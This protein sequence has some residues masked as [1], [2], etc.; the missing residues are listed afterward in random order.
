M[1]DFACYIERQAFFGAMRACEA[2][3]IQSGSPYPADLFELVT[4]KTWMATLSIHPRAHL[5]AATLVTKDSF[6]TDPKLAAQNA[7]TTLEHIRSI[8]PF[9]IGLGEPPAPAAI[10]KDGVKHGVVKLGWSWENRFVLKFE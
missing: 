4:S 5:P 9:E 2:V 7:L 1:G 8:C 6:M 10:N 3:G